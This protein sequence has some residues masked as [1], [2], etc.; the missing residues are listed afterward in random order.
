MHNEY[1]LIFLPGSGGVCF[2]VLSTVTS[3]TVLEISSAFFT[4]VETAPGLVIL[5]SSLLR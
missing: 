4:G 3:S 1:I 2:S 5:S